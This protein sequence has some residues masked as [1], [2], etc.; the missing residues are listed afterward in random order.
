MADDA[1]DLKPG[2][3]QIVIEE[4][5]KTTRPSEIT[6]ETGGKT[7][8]DVKITEKGSVTTQTA[9]S[10]SVASTES[11]DETTK[12]T[13]PP[14]E[15][16][17]GSPSVKDN[18]PIAP[19]EVSRP[20]ETPREESAIKPDNGKINE[21]GRVEKPKEKP[22]SELTEEER[23]NKNSQAADKA[24]KNEP[25]AKVTK[26]NSPTGNWRDRAK[27]FQGN[28]KDKIKNLSKQKAKD[29]V[30]KAASAAAKR[31]SAMAL[32]A[33][34][35]PALIGCL[36]IFIIVV[37]IFGTMFCLAGSGYPGGKSFN[38]A[39][40]KNDPNIKAIIAAT[41]ITT[42]AGLHKIDFAN[43]KDKAYVESGK[44]DKRL[45]A[46]LKYISDKHDHIRISHIV[47]GYE[48][49]PIDPE[50]GNLHD[51][52]IIKNISAHKEGLAADI[53]EIDF[54]KKK[55][56]CGDPIPVKIVWQA[57][58]DSLLGAAD[59]NI[60]DA[61]RN[62][63]DLA[64]P[65]IKDAL[66]QMGVQGLNQDDIFEKLSQI[67]G[68]NSPFDLTK[69]DVIEALKK[70][71]VT[72][73]DGN[74]LQSGL[75]KISAFENI[76]SANPTDLAGLM[77]L[78]GSNGIIGINFNDDLN[79]A[80]AKMRTAQSLAGLDS[81][82]AM[83]SSDAL[84]ALSDLGLKSKSPLLT[85]AYQESL[86][87]TL[88]K[89]AAAQTINKI[90]SST[91]LDQVKAALAKLGKS[92]TDQ[93]AEK[94]IAAVK[95]YNEYKEIFALS[96]DTIVAEPNLYQ[97]LEDMG[98]TLDNQDAQK[99][100][101]TY[102]S[103]VQVDSW[104]G[105]VADT[106]FFAALSNL[107]ISYSD[108]NFSFI[109]DYK[110]AQYLSQFDGNLSLANDTSNSFKISDVNVNIYDDPQAKA[111][112]KDLGIS[113][114]KLPSLKGK[115]PLEIL[116][117]YTDWEN[118]LPTEFGKLEDMQAILSVRSLDNLQDSLVQDALN[119]FNINFP[120]EIGKIAN[121]SDLQALASITSVSDLANLNITSALQDLGFTADTQKLLAQYTQISDLANLKSFADLG[122]ADVQ[123]SLAGLGLDVNQF[124]DML[125]PLG[126]INS[127]MNI[128]NPGDLL[129]PDVLKGLDGLGVISLNSEILSQL[130]PVSALLNVQSIGDL[131]NPDALSALN[132]LGILSF[133]NP[134]LA[135]LSAIDMIS[136]ILGIDVFGGVLGSCRKGHTRCYTP[137][138]RN[139]V[140][141]AISELLQFPYD[142]DGGK[143]TMYWRI[144]QIIT[145]SK[146]RD[147]DKF[148]DKLNK[149][150]DYVRPANFGLFAM[151]EAHDHL[152]IAY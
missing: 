106:D 116:G 74:I 52:Q 96:P 64:S 104:T 97:K 16:T 84:K 88:E 8:T 26:P 17:G 142:M 119:N 101:E 1:K 118:K 109:E 38:Q 141:Q 120:G 98:I 150:Y 76:I 20:A 103:M 72:G 112:L 131:L 28:A 70:I 92:A 29:A 48:D 77:G 122:L 115:N 59:T 34:G 60:L 102:K 6:I 146:E 108:Q 149:L 144:N 43:P 71:G 44:I 27:S 2:E 90:D 130:G 68:L 129:S 152:H 58:N 73:I 135:A 123:A 80:I 91:T 3:E 7:T 62:P 145:F 137:T 30:K 31:L 100:F 110:E 61:I 42:K 9:G 139:N 36:I 53:D 128:S 14:A 46:A 19:A 24:L 32:S 39:A 78:T 51:R 18:G 93:D 105:N 37:A 25:K 63:S 143:N 99:L 124:K 89:M 117:Q 4:E 81:F 41:N 140:H 113:E 40:G 69:P 21:G 11:Q 67:S 133:S 114:D 22:D 5:T 138:A 79:Q 65:D 132:A 107:G 87:Q 66:E 148:A 54:V 15:E 13:Q 57:K 75:S 127:L 55:C 126:G 35:W 82:S 86:K 10:P 50:S 151:P 121:L 95:D 94:L 47:S 125:G 111:Y 49:M 85:T 23:K 56:R 83:T 136:N 147:V 45:A 12:T 134:V 33:I